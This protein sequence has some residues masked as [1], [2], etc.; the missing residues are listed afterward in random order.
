MSILEV[1]Q[2][3]K[4]FGGLVAVNDASFTV[5]ENQITCLIGPNGSGKTTIFNLITGAIPADGG[6]VRYRGEELLGKRVVQTVALGV[7][8]TFQDLKLF[9]EFTV[10]QNVTVAMGGRHGETVL[11]GLSYNEKSEKARADLEKAQEILALFGLSDAA[12]TPVRSLPYGMQ[13][14]VS[15]ARLYAVDA[16]L[17]LLDEPASGMDHDGY[18]VLE[19]A[20]SIFIAGGKTILLVEHNIDFVKAVAHKVVFLHQGQV[21]AQ[22]SIDQIT[23]DRRLTEIY[24]GF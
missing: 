1:S 9:G 7:A 12:E 13:K 19:K 22:G 16:D 2:L 3:T 6:S 24:F 11:G 4:K 21:L 23:A 8:R 17:L 14:L 15:L 10:L 18:G 5:E 20:L